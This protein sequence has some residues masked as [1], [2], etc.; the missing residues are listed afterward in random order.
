MQV[1]TLMQNLD[2]HTTGIATTIRTQVSTTLKIPLG[3]HRVLPQPKATL[4]MQHIGTTISGCTIRTLLPM[5]P[6]F[7]ATEGIV[8]GNSLE[9][10]PKLRME[11]TYTSATTL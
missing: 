6:R 4:T 10:I 5:P 9:R 8:R 2:G 11:P 7:G 1:S 3:L